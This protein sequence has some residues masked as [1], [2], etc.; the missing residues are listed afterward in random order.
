MAITSRVVYLRVAIE[1]ENG[2]APVS[3]DL[4]DVATWAT[5]RLDTRDIAVDVTAYHSAQNLVLDEVAGYFATPERTTMAKTPSLYLDCSSAYLSRHTR[6]RLEEGDNFGAAV[7]VAPY[8]L[9]VFI[10]IPSPDEEEGTRF[11]GMPPDL[12]SVLKYAEARS[13]LLVRFDRDGDEYPEL[14]I[15]P[16]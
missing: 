12:V 4:S 5:A 7:S 11:G 8:D 2:L 15:Q 3:D 6:S 14:V 13:C 10:T 1:A 9:G 16:D